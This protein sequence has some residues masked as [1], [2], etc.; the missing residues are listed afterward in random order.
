MSRSRVPW[1]TVGLLVLAVVTAA[2]AS[3]ALHATAPAPA[4]RASPSALASPR[5]AIQPL[6]D[7]VDRSTAYRGAQGTCEGGAVLE[8]STDGGHSWLPVALPVTNVMALDAR[9]RSALD[10]VGTGGSAQTAPCVA[11]LWSSRDAAHSWSGPADPSSTWFRDPSQPA[12]LHTPTGDVPTPCPDPTLPAVQLVALSTTEGVLMCHGGGVYRTVDAGARWV[13]RAVL[14]GAVAM[15]WRGGDRGWLLDASGSG[16]PSLTLMRTADGGTT[17][18]SGGCVGGA[19]SKVGDGPSLAFA[20][21]DVGMAMVGDRVFT[22][23]DGGT[24]WTDVG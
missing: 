16:C 8:R 17:W 2:V 5:D 14:P 13:Q 9:V 15:A 23:D 6:L 22:T 11:Q 7:I 4:A 24:T 3:V 19:T 21:A 18:R 12:Q 20:D 1:S 10:V